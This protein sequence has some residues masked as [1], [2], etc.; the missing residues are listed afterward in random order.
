LVVPP[1]ALVLIRCLRVPFS[2]NVERVALAAGH[3]GIEI[4]WIDVDPDDR[5][6]V[7]ALSGQ[8]L[9]PVL[10]AGDEVVSDSPRILDW[11]ED[12]F[13]EPPLL[14]HDPAA[15]AEVRIFVEWFNRVWKTW[16][17]GINDGVG[18]PAEHAAEM[19]RAVELF[20]ALRQRRDFLFGEFG[21]ADVT[22]FPFLKY[23]SLGLS[24][25]DDDPFHAVLVEHMPLRPDS[26]LHAWVAR[27]DARPRG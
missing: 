25:A 6:P 19:R 11:L 26:P 2:T 21:L 23:A 9:V 17:N 1:Q 16:P 15:R 3:K 20:E 24:A 22:A 14:P 7:E 27:I 13:P 5:S 18:D 8:P 10:V 12:R 4:D